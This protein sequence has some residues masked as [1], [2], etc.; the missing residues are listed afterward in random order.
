M[1]RS[2]RTGF[3]VPLLECRKDITRQEAIKRWRERGQQGCQA[4]SRRSELAL[5]PA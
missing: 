2:A 3:Q 4:C 1:A 5:Q